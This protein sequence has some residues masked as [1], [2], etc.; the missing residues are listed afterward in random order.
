MLQPQEAAG[1]GVQPERFDE[2]NYL[3]GRFPNFQV[4]DRAYYLGSSKEASKSG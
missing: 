3:A 2:I 4:S 1:C